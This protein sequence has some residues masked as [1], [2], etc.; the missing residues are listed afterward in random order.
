EY[1]LNA[2]DVAAGALIVQEAGGTV[3]DFKGGDDFLF[4]RE[5]IAGNAAQPQMLK[6][7]QKHWGK[8]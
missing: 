4:G 2:W 5:I 1:N 7:I 6:V 8:K 3:T